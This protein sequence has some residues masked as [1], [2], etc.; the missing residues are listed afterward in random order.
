MIC[1]TTHGTAKRLNL[2]DHDLSIP[3][4][5]FLTHLDD[6]YEG[7][8]EH[9]DLVI[10]VAMAG[11]CPKSERSWSNA[12]VVWSAISALGNPKHP[13]SQKRV[14]RACT[15]QAQ[16]TSSNRSQAN[17]DRTSSGSVFCP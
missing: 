8:G 1:H 5:D 17:R 6:T 10:A 13:A 16:E 11:W 14:S 2:L 7:A 15:G 9:D 12:R 3:G 4:G